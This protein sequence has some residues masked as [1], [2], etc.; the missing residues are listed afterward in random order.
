MIG[1]IKMNSRFDNIIDRHNTNSIKYD[2]IKEHQY[3][4]DILPLWVADMDF[5]SP[6]EVITALSQL[7]E[8]GIYGYTGIKEPYFL[9][10][11]HWFSSRFSW[12]VQED[13]LVCTPTVVSALSVAV[14][15][16]TKEGDSVLIQR[17]VYRPFT[18]VVETNKRK[19]INNPLLYHN[20]KYQIDF[21]DF[22]RKIVEHK[23]KLFILCSPHNPVGRVWTKE[24]LTE[25][26]NICLKHDVL[27]LSDEIHCDFIY[28]GFQHTIFASISEA[29]ANHC[30]I[31][32][33]PT[34]TFNLAGLQSSNIF[35]PN[36]KLRA[37]FQSALEEIKSPSPNLFGITACQTA[38]TYGEPWLEELKEYLSS[39]ISYVRNF[40]IENLPMLHL[41]EPEGTYLLWIDFSELGLSEEELENFI[42]YKAKLWLNAGTMFGEEG[43]QFERLNI[44]C[45]R[46]I[47]EQA[48]DR[49]K[50]V[51]KE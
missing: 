14:R 5:Q 43:K 36:P 44:A 6:P 20:G 7:A 24:E 3:P 11:S 50:R 35:I 21:E 49:L 9:A 28:K 4:D 1:G 15:T 41:V 23:V 22:E 46:K 47:L 26:G 30:I 8:H 40:L 39:N 31:C 10:L 45:P 51:V 29:F 33:A 27:V 25:M 17:P 37:Q 38:Y 19:V 34:K 2:F 16:F 18:H 42:I 12:N 13:W 32:T 48:M